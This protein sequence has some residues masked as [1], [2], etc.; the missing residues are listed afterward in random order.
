MAC[1]EQALRLMRLRAG[2]ASSS[3]T[4]TGRSSISELTQRSEANERE[5]SRLHEGVLRC[6]Q[7]AGHFDAVI[8]YVAGSYELTRSKHIAASLRPYAIKASWRLSQWPMLQQLLSSTEH[9]TGMHRSTTSLVTY[10]VNLGRAV[11]ALAGGCPSP[12]Q[13]PLE[14]SS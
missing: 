12:W 4:D 3:E 6:L 14:C 8:Q 10:E 11:H 1:Y 13:R 7:N 5:L 2:R 9:E